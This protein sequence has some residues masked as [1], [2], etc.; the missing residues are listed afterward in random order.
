M[1]AEREAVRERGVV[2]HERLGDVIGGDHRAH[3]HDR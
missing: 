1:T 2:A 3:R